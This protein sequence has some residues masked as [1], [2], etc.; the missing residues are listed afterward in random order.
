MN[1]R[2]GKLRFTKYE[3]ETKNERKNRAWRKKNCCWRGNPMEKPDVTSNNTHRITLPLWMKWGANAF[4]SIHDS[5]EMN[6]EWEYNAF[7]KQRVHKKI[8]TSK[9]YN[10]AIFTFVFFSHANGS[11]CAI[12]PPTVPR[13]SSQLVF[14]WLRLVLT[15]RGITS[16]E[17]M[18]K[19]WR[20]TRYWIVG[21]YQAVAQTKASELN[22]ILKH[23]FERIKDLLCIIIY[24]I[25]TY[26]L[27]KQSETKT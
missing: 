25:S 2:W 20:W 27:A 19:G 14:I 1:T 4:Q 7:N 3:R 11:L 9:T 5:N 26:Q 18:N 13:S 8:I 24:R 21:E 15:W 12:L 6:L 16:M 22:S 10:S 23:F 17:N